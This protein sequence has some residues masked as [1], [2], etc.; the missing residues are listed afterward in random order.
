MTSHH[1]IGCSVQLCNVFRNLLKLPISGYNTTGCDVLSFCYKLSEKNITLTGHSSYVA[2][3]IELKNSIG[4]G[5]IRL[6][7]CSYDKTIKIWDLND[8]QCLQTLTGHTESVTNII[9][10]KNGLLVSCSVNGIIKIWDLNGINKCCQ[11]LMGDIDCE[12]N[13]IEL[14]NTPEYDIRIASCNIGG[15]I[16]IWGLNGNYYQMDTNH[17]SSIRRIIELKNKQIATCNIYGTIKIWDLNGKCCQTIIGTYW[18][19]H[20][21]EL[22]NGQIAT[23]SGGR[24]IELWNLNSGKCCQEFIG[25]TCNIIELKTGQLASCS[26]GK[27]IKIWG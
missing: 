15:T 25:H 17:S 24:K 23:R 10:L 27:T 19:D 12:T 2:K 7:S 9:E 20:I 1:K 13:I 11:T 5:S 3:I 21:I 18:M 16:K 14:K 26:Y 8:N 22:K 4:C 6:A